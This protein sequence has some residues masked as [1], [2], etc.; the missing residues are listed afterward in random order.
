MFHI[1]LSIIYYTLAKLSS[2][3][4]GLFA[5]LVTSCLDIT[6]CQ[7][8]VLERFYSFWRGNFLFSTSSFSVLP[9]KPSLLQRNIQESMFFS[10]VTFIIHY[11]TTNSSTTPCSL[12]GVYPSAPI[13]GGIWGSPQSGPPVSW[14]FHSSWAHILKFL[15]RHF[16]SLYLMSILF[17]LP[18]WLLLY[19]KI[20]VSGI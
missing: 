12:R 17:Q 19:V 14:T 4:S 2:R 8:H 15:H 10:N 7:I 5:L 11:T 16:P 13:F 3:N 1:S 20:N 9:S 6:C 18:R